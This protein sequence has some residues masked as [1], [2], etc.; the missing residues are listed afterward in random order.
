MYISVARIFKDQFCKISKH[1]SMPVH[2]EWGLN[3]DASGASKE[4]GHAPGKLFATTH[5]ISFEN[6]PVVINWPF[7]GAANDN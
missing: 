2:N 6:S 3:Q 7:N 5:F 1:G 4:G